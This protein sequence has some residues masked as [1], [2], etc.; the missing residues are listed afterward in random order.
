MGNSKIKLFSAPLQGYTDAPWRNIHNELF[1]GIDTYYT[2]FLRIERGTFRNRDLRDV[3]PENNAVPELVPQIIACAPDKIIIM[4]DKLKD[5]GYKKIDINLG[6]P[7]P[8]IANKCMGS[9]MLPYPARI[10]ELFETLS[11]Y[12]PDISFSVKM[13]LGYNRPD[14]ALALIPYFDIINPEHIT[15]HPRLGIQQYKGDADIGSF[16]EFYNN[17]NYELVY[18]G[19]ITSAEVIDSVISEFPELKGIMIGRGLLSY[20]FLARQYKGGSGFDMEEIKVFHDRLYEYYESKLQGEAQLLNKMKTI[21]DYLYP[22]LDK[23]L[24]KS[25]KKSSSIVKYHAAINKL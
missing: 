15:V 22:L 23:K 20:P 11:H 7:F 12:K 17:C 3:L 25:I 19:D 4:A 5:L 21:W 14:E 13:R 8:L 1:G 24:L 9:G 16:R 6:C 10:K 2:P 18:N